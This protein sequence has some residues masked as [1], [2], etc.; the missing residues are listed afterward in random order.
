MQIIQIF[1]EDYPNN[2]IVPFTY[3]SEYYYDIEVVKKDR[4]KGW[5]F[6][7]EKKEFKEPFTK[8]LKEKVFEPHK[9]NAEYYLA[10]NDSGE[11]IGLLVIGKQSWNNLLRIWDIYIIED[12]QQKGIGTKLLQFTEK[13]AKILKIR[14]IILESQ[15]SNF[16]A[17]QFYLKFGF[18]LTGLDLV[19]YSNT[20]RE[21][22]EVRLEMTKLL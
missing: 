14:G 17:I 10:A 7:L 20:D 11:E 15:S 21:K 3:T 18:E 16:P 4:N 5:N 8:Y 6:N 9:K 19:A 2:K 12:W 1:E 13:R 22:N